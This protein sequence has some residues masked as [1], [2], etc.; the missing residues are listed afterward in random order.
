MWK[1]DEFVISDDR[2]L[3]EFDMV[4]CF[5][6]EESYWGKERSREGMSEALNRSVLCFGMFIDERGMHKQIGFARVAGDNAYFGLLADVFI[7][8]EYRGRGLGKWLI[9]TIAHHP[10]VSKLRKFILYTN[11]PDFYRH[12]DFDL[13]DQSGVAKFMELQKK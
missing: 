12:N 5:I 7:L 3:I 13:Y 2:S 1:K 8:K 6:T 10:D 11:T 9:H 4:Y